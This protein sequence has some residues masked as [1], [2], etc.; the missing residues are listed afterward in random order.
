MAKKP[1]N[2][3]PIRKRPTKKTADAIAFFK[4]KK[5][6]VEL[7]EAGDGRRKLQISPTAGQTTLSDRFYNAIEGK[8]KY[9]ALGI[10]TAI[11]SLAIYWMMMQ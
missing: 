4:D 11:V 5:S 6:A 8:G 1:S 10:T 7:L 2:Q 9:V 3:T